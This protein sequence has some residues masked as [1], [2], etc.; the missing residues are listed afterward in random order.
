MNNAAANKLDYYLMPRSTIR[1][2]AD[3][4]TPAR[5]Q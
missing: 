1:P 2:V 5:S 3:A 4:A